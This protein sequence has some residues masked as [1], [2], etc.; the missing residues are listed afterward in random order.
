MK[1]R[2]IALALSMTAAIIMG[3]QPAFASDQL[4]YVALGADLNSEQRATVLKLL[5][6]TES[7][8]THDTVVTVTNAEEHEYL[9]SYVSSSVIGTRA[10][11]SCKVLEE[12]KGH[13]ITVEVHNITYVTPAM[14]ENALAT[15]GMK[16]ASVVV[17]GPVPISGTA[18]LVGAMK[19]YA[20]MHGTPISPEL[21]DSATDE[22]VKTGELADSLGDSE[23]AAELIAA[24]KQVIAENDL[25][26]KDDINRAIDEVAGKLEISLSEEDRQLIL[27]LMEK[28]SALDLDADNLAEQARGIYSELQQ[29]GFSLS[30]YGIT[31]E[32]AQGLL[33]RLIQFIKELLSSLGNK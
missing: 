20:Q 15:A 14:Y 24:L 10:L 29:R 8:L 12:G 30:D 18:A 26:T 13:G 22:L 11:S 5:G 25:A 6:I 17:A 4:P 1:L 28:L 2:N 21:I 9:D 33:A 19:A 7:D 27:D 3:A 16:N 32:E 23:E 31:K